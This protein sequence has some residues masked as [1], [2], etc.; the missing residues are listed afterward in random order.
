LS[1]ISF[2][3]SSNAKVKVDKDDVAKAKVSET[4][5]FISWDLPDGRQ[6]LKVRSGKTEKLAF[7]YKVT[8]PPEA[9]TRSIWSRGTEQRPHFGD[10]RHG[11]HP[12]FVFI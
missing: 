6:G 11:G 10:D 12:F 7:K 1:K 2:L 3:Q 9:E 5:G 4:T 8:Y